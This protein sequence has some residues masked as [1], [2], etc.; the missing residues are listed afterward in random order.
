MTDRVLNNKVKKLKA[1]QEQTAELDRVIKELETVIKDE[2][3]AREVE[4]L[5]SG[6][7]T[8]RYKEVISNRFDSKTFKTAYESL[9]NQYLKVTTTKRFTIA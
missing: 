5:K 8:V 9:Y 6:D 2:M 4:E 3:T 7:Y 1:L